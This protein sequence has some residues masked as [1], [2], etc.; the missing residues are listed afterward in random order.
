MGRS[1]RTNLRANDTSVWLQQSG[2]VS[3]RKT[4]FAS[5]WCFRDD[6]GDDD[7]DDDDE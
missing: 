4:A 5:V 3:Q 7:D 2:S 6:D 1:S